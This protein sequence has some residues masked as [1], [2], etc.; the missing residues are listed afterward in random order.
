MKRSWVLYALLFEIDKPSA[1]A[2]LRLDIVNLSVSV[3][4]LDIDVTLPCLSKRQYQ[5][6]MCQ[7][8]MLLYIGVSIR[9]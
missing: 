1:V 3:L 7:V 4:R 9:S 8:R 6:L 2:V 5:N